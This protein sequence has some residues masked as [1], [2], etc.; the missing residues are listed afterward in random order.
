[1][2]SSAAAARSE[3]VVKITEGYFPPD[4]NC[5]DRQIKMAKKQLRD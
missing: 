1:M 4:R 5:S 2:L 3:Q